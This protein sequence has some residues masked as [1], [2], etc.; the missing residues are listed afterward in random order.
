MSSESSAYEVKQNTGKDQATVVYPSTSME[1]RE[2]TN[3]DPSAIEAGHETISA[4]PQS[5]PSSPPDG[6]WDA[7]L[8]VL[9]SWMLVFN[10]WGK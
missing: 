1:K 4:S 9:C 6:G 10:T 2:T 5:N 3:D 7:W 8:Q